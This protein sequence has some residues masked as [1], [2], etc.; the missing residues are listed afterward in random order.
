MDAEVRG[1]IKVCASVFAI[2]VVIIGSG[3][4]GCPVYNVWS[5]GLAGQAQLRQAEQNRQIKVQEAHAT[6]EASKLLAQAEIERSK[7]VAEANKIIAGGLGGPEGYLRY[8]YIHA[9]SE[10]K[11]TQYVYIPTEAAMPVLEARPKPW[12][13]GPQ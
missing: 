12:I 11:N 10:N 1:V 9:M 2:V 7:G 6:L 3:M 5:A 4:A 13:R 8:L